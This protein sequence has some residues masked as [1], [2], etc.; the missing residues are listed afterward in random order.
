[1]S[2]IIAVTSGK[3]GVGKTH[4]SVN[5]ALQCA[6]AGLRTCLFDAD[7]GLANVNLLL[8]LASRQTLA[9]V[10][11]SRC[12]LQDIVQSAFGID[13]IP[14]S[15]GIECMADLPPADLRRLSREFRALGSAGW[16]IARLSAH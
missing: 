1:M 7:L 13:I 2:R 6:G 14:G 15:A 10:L 8:K 3:G 12:S 11:A 5:L 4:L 16:L 9:D